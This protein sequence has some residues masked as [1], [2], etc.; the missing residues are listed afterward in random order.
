MVSTMPAMPGSV[1]AASW[2]RQSATL[3]FAGPGCAGSSMMAAS[4][5]T[6]TR[7]SARSGPLHW[8]VRTTCSPAVIAA[9]SAGPRSARWSKPPS[10]TTS[11]PTPTSQTCS[12]AWSMAILPTASTSCSHGTGQPKTPSTANDVQ[13][14]DAYGTCLS[15]RRLHA[16]HWFPSFDLLVRRMVLAGELEKGKG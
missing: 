8:A 15:V 2:P 4:N 13:P 3:L 1:S 14:P 6:P 11:N 10:S 5:S 7:L 9:R 16:C 12:S